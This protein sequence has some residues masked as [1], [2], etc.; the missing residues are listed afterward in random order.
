M[1]DKP[2][3]SIREN[4]VFGHG[5]GQPL[6]CDVFTP[7]ERAGNA[8]APGV[9]L[10]H[11]GAW[12]SGDRSQMR[13]YGV[14]LALQGF[15]CVSSS[16]RLVPTTP[17]PAQIH[18]VNA[19]LRY[20][21]ANAGELGIDAEQ[22]ASVGASAGAHLV[23]L[24]AGTIGR[25]EFEGDGGHPGVSTHVAAT[26][27]IFPPTVLSPRGV[28]LSGAVPANVLLLDADDEDSARMASPVT[29]V[30]SEYPPTLL[31]HGTADRIV[32]PSASIRMYEVLV[33]AQVP[34]ELHMVAEQP[35][36]YVLQRDFH[37]LS[38]TQ[39]SMFLRR[40]LGL[41]P[42]VAMPVWAQSMV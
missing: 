40:Y 38:C 14:Q 19:A 8:L 20:M 41:Q 27:G 12:R 13:A 6:L 16:Y 3:V 25:V 22:I 24:S 11:G 39:I 42:K 23:L 5:G 1:S 15:V 4:V 7:P 34:V 21:R 28:E 32:P 31:L 33:S 26:V 30:T 35:H 10:V 18:D 29:H 9:L 36:G 2:Q 17:W 37:R